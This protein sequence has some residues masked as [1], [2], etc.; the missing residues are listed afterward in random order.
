MR[1]Y[2]NKE[3]VINRPTS[4][5]V[6]MMKNMYGVSDYGWTTSMSVSDISM[7][8][9]PSASNKIWRFIFGRS[10]HDYNRGSRL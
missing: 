9:R 4:S 3:V 2:A 8:I 5:Q 6:L 1:D 10:N 7:T